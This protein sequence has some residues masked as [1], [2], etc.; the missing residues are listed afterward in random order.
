MDYDRE[1][2]SLYFTD[3]VSGDIGVI[4]EASTATGAAVVARTINI[5]STNTRAIVDPVLPL[6][7]S[8]SIP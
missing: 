5:G 7:P 1:T 8:S 2:D 6:E 4:E 3:I